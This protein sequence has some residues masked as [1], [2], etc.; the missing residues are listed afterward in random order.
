MP[1]RLDPQCPAARYVAG[2][3]PHREGVVCGVLRNEGRKADGITEGPGHEYLTVGGDPSTVYGFCC[4]RAVPA[5]TEAQAKDDENAR[6]H[7]TFCPI[8][9]AEKERIWAERERAW[10]AKSKVLTPS[11]D[12]LAGIS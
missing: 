9:Q 12:Q 3:V 1:D 10:Q 4:G 11:L 7:Y 8:W 2:A 6:G 5:W